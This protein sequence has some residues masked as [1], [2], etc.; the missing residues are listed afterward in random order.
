MAEARWVFAGPGSP[1]YALRQWRPTVMPRLLED[2][3]VH[4]GCLVF[5]SAAALTLGRWTRVRSTRST[6]WA[7][8]RFG[9]TAWTC[10]R[11]SART[12]P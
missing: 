7:P 3:L 6:K 1:T 4:G 12:S 9:K 2:K 10:R 11:P 5:A 8:T